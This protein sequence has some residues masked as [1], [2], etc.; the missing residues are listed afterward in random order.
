MDVKEA[1]SGRKEDENLMTQTI[2]ESLTNV[3][4]DNEDKPCLVEKSNLEGPDSSKGNKEVSLENKLGK[5]E[6]KEDYFPREHQVDARDTLDKVA[7]QYNTT[8]T[9]LAQYNRLTSRFIF[10]GQVCNSTGCGTINK[11]A[12]FS[13]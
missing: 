1:A 11:P 6:I 9:R 3:E 13:S 2:S 4:P 7:A 8:P 5:L 12:T 10:A